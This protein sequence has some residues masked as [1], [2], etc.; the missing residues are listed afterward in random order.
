[1]GLGWVI[2][3]KAY[4]EY[5]AAREGNSNNVAEYM[6]LIRLLETIAAVPSPGDLRISGDSQLVILQ[7]LGE[8]SV[9]AK[10]IVPLHAKATRLI[11]KLTA[12]GWTVLLR[13]VD[14]RENTRADAASSA[15]LVENGV[16]VAQ[17]HPAPGF[18]S[19]FR[20]MAEALGISSIAFGKSVDSLGLRGA[21]KMPPQRRSKTDM[22]ESGLMGLRLPL[23]GRRRRPVLPWLPFSPTNP[24]LP[25]SP[26][27]AQNPNLIRSWSSTSAAMR[28][29]LGAGPPEESS[30][31]WLNRSARIVLPATRSGSPRSAPRCWRSVHRETRW[32]MPLKP[33]SRTGNSAPACSLHAGASGP[34]MNAREHWTPTEGRAKNQD[35]N[36]PF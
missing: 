33:W 3:R 4:H 14:R 6:A 25:R 17:Y 35:F 30:Q 9:G 1:M 24:A 22:R 21:D 5:V 16:E 12:A 13:W 27:R 10:H 18:T 34:T 28:P 20:E 31:R 11:E 32:P 23:T 15:A 7:I 26:Q 2:G 29:P 19:R 36:R 8:W